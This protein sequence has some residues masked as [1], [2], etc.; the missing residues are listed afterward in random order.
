M[1]KDNLNKLINLSQQATFEILKKFNIPDIKL[2]IPF[3]Y[4]I[5]F[6]DY[7]EWRYI[8]DEIDS[9]IIEFI[10]DNGEFCII[11]ISPRVYDY[12]NFILV[13]YENALPYNY[14]CIIFDKI[15]QI[16]NLY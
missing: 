6:K 4:S 1:K 5:Q 16:K 14:T 7:V 9:E 3:M 8:N 11:E 15:K 10:E 12:E 13:F 2:H